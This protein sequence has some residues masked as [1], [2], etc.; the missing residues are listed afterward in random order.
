M[1]NITTEEKCCNFF[2]DELKSCYREME[3]YEKKI[4]QLENQKMDGSCRR[5]SEKNLARYARAGVST[6]ADKEI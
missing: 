4:E 5:A 2:I 6:E 1:S 3:Q